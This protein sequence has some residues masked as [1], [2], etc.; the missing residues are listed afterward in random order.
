MNPT[1]IPDFVLTKSFT[2]EVRQALGLTE[3]T[4]NVIVLKQE[5][6]FGKKP[7]DGDPE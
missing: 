3:T 1:H 2:R 6:Q 7:H 4:E 5:T